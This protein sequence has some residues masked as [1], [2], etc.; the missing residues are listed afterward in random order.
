MS[1]ILDESAA[2]YFEVIAKEVPG[3]QQTGITAM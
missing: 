1:W 3:N 2:G